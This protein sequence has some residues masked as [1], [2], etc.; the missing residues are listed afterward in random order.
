MAGLKPAY[1][2]SGDDD[3]KIDA[4]R[5]RVRKRAEDENGPGA[6]ET[7]TAP[8]DLPEAVATALTTLTFASG[9][10][11]LLADGI[12]QWK[13]G[14]LDPLEREL[15]AVPE[16]TVLVLIARGKPPARLVKAIEKAAGEHREYS[17][18]KPW[19]MPKWAAE[20]AREEGLNLD[21][22]AAKALVAIV[23][24]RQQRL[25][26]EVER[27]AIL[28]HPRTQL[29]AAEVS[30]L[31]AGEATQQV[32]DL[33]DALVAGDVP[34]SLSFAERLTSSGEDRPSKL[35]FPIVR[36]LRD[37]HRAAELLDAG[38]PEAKVAGAMKMPPWAAKRTLTQAKKADREGLARA[39]CAFADLEI[40][41]RGGGAG[42]D[43]D[44]A[45]SLTLARAA[46]G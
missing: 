39:L 23:G 31:A 15:A 4:W 38:V 33:A 37:V 11:Y 44:T 18:P 3:P 25:A 35:V 41:L 32:Y 30:R 9:D 28:A 6:L 20:R 7:F 26:R 46:A 43:E 22:E 29:S 5:T 21:Q 14:D 17:A 42:L 34:A 2:I 13:A 24:T 19:Q 10:R 8:G 45:F 16:G 40:E 12:E 1:L 27:L 36:R